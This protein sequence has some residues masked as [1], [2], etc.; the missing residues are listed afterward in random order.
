[1]KGVGLHLPDC[2]VE[3][4]AEPFPLEAIRSPR[5]PVVCTIAIILLHQKSPVYCS[6]PFCRIDTSF[7]EA[8]ATGK[9]HVHESASYQHETEV[10]GTKV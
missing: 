9:P 8:E 2:V 10:R 3:A 1:M 4:R 6:L 5:R 7:I